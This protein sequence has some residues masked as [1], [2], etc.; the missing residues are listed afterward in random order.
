M[1]KYYFKYNLPHL[2]KRI[3]P[4]NLETGYS[5]KSQQQLG[6]PIEFNIGLLVKANREDWDVFLTLSLQTQEL[7]VDYWLRQ[8]RGLGVTRREVNRHARTK[9][10]SLKW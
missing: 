5:I 2:W 4:L 6:T 10:L 1:L 7:K 3:R 9:T 8:Q